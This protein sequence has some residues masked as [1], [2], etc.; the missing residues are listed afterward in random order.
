MGKEPF[1]KRGKGSQEKDAKAG[2]SGASD[3]RK[4]GDPVPDDPDVEDFQERFKKRIEEAYEKEWEEFEKKIR[5]K[6]V[7]SLVGT[8]DVGKSATIN[9]LTGKK[10]ADVQATAGSTK[11]VALYELTAM[12]VSESLV[13][14]KRGRTYLQSATGNESNTPTHTLNNAILGQEKCNVWKG[15]DA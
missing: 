8:V 11:Y 3:S 6:L 2:S 15:K 13:S 1:W 7:I 9:A 4:E 5:E 10:L 14:R 12:Q